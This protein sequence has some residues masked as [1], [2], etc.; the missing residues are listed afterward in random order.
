M[1]QI[2]SKGCLKSSYVPGLAIRPLSGEGRCSEEMAK[3]K[4]KSQTR[5]SLDAINTQYSTSYNPRVQKMI[6]SE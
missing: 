2:E 1:K 6:M 4:K 5:T 3:K